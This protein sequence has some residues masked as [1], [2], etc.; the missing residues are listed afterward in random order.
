MP[1]SDSQ[2]PTDRRLWLIPIGLALI[3]IAAAIVV[4]GPQ[5]MGQNEAAS[6]QS[7]PPFSGTAESG[8]APLESGLD[9]LPEPGSLA[10]DFALPDLAG[11]TVR[12]S[13][14]AG[15]PV[16]LNF[17][18]TWCAPCRVEMPELARAAADYAAAG[19]VVLPI[20]QEETAEQVREF[21]DEVGLDLPALLD[22]KADVGLA[23]G[24]FFLPSTVIVGPDGIIS[25]YHR[26]IISR[27][28]I[29]AYLEEMGS[30]DL[31]D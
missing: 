10:P 7:I 14:F 2:Q 22:S 28:A 17:W 5:F 21:Y 26:G 29:D 25:A 12:L 15:R 24:A 19:V 8:A 1:P 18:A 9:D 23:Y 31:A 13:D 16:I 4:F 30:A 3:V 27:D 20:N 6:L 11:E